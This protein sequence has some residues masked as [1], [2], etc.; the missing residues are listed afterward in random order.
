MTRTIVHFSA[1]YWEHF[2]PVQ[3]VVEPAQRAGFQVLHGNE[4]DHASARLEFYPERVEEADLV[5]IQRDFP[6]HFEVYTEI[7]ARASAL[8]K[9]VLYEWDDL[10]TELP[11]EHPD[12]EKYMSVRT[13]VLTAL[14]EADAVTCATPFLADYARQFNPHVW[15]LP[16]YLNDRFW[17]LRPVPEDT[18][19]PRPLTI[20]YLG[21]HSHK[22]DLAMLAPV[23]EGLLKSYGERLRLQLWNISPPESLAGLPNVEKPWPGLVNYQAFVDF[24][25]KQDCDIVIAPLLESDFNRGKSWQKFIEY[26]AL[27][28][29]GVYSRITPYEEVVE[30]GKNGFLAYSLSEWESSLRALIDDASL[31]L[32]L[33]RAAQE[34]VHEAWMLSDLFHRWDEV[35]T[36]VASLPLEA[37]KPAGASARKL[38]HWE[39]QVLER[40]EAMRQEFDHALAGKE[41]AIQALSQTLRE[42]E[43][44]IQKLDEKITRLELT[45]QARERAITGFQR[46]VVEKDSTLLAVRGSLHETSKTLNAILSSPGWKM[47]EIVYRI[48]L[49]LAPRGSSRERLLHMMIKSAHALKTGGIGGFLSKATT[50]LRSQP[51]PS[52]PVSPPGQAL[53]AFEVTGSEPCPAPAISLVVLDG[54]SIEAVQDWARRQTIDS[55][56]IILW[57]KEAAYAR[58]LTAPIREWQ[59]G[60]VAGLC[61][62]LVG[63][64][65][66]LASDDL[67]QQSCTYLEEN[68]LALEGENLAFTV[69]ISW[70]SDGALQRVNGGRSPRA[71]VRPLQGLIVRKDCL[72]EGFSL[73]LA[74]WVKNENAQAVAGKVIRHIS[75]RREGA[76]TAPFDTIPGEIEVRLEGAYILARHRSNLPWQPMVHAL[77]SMSAGL[78]PERSSSDLPTVLVVFPFLAVGGAEQIHLKVMQKLKE[79]IRF[80]IVTYEPLDPTQGTTADAFREITPYIY[81]LHE[82][83]HPV[84]FASFTHSLVR[85]FE[86]KTLYIAN[87][88]VWIYDALGELKERYPDLRIVDQVYDSNVGWINR[89]DLGVVLHTDRH[90]GVNERICRAYIEK[91][92]P[93]EQVHLIE[94][95]IEPQELD[96]NGYDPAQIAA[97]KHKLGLSGEKKVITFASRLHP[98]KRPMDFV[99]LCRR[100]AHDP[101]LTFLM[102]GDG[103]LADEVGAQIARSSLKNIS[104]HRFYRPISD[105]FAVSDVFVLPSEFEGMP[106]VVIE[107]QAMGKPVV[108]TDVGNNREIVEYTQGGVVVPQI[109]DIAALAEGVRRMLDN[110]PDPA[111]LRQVALGRF[112][113]A[114][115]AEKYYKVLV[116]EAHA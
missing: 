33:G 83:M 46:E 8:H 94:N 1:D 71:G 88:A 104:R 20:G 63:R 66:C 53:L 37:H 81:T 57:D 12:Y 58:S 26:S 3:R 4:W 39:R 79:R 114:L 116:G 2:C 44:T 69:N 115:V 32:R 82:F 112:D 56:E 23:L 14:V 76:E 24:F 41:S 28:V 25:L 85:R 5:V 113:I 29:P 74:P 49:V 78:L 55:Y 42:H 91:G 21:A 73:D 110:P 87:G 30:H 47:L 86:P 90:I 95:G 80:A 89:Y 108:V 43:Q 106:M 45:I 97:L 50:R 16:N 40:S 17:H 22:P 60:D 10:L 65:V 100:F 59:A 38:Y 7:M 15:V 67:L 6:R 13:A 96:P 99:E 61:Q 92:A 75:S 48:R 68:L 107:A 64:Y 103:P 31:R 93:P 105:I 102:V 19:E 54:L 98:Q 52:A 35:Y 70:Q 111:R 34:T 51:E 62:G 101:T 109:G 72:G 84:H 11:E 9:P 77:K 36:R 27:G 18:P